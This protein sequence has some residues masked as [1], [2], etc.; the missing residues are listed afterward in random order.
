MEDKTILLNKLKT[1]IALHEKMSKSYFF[2]PPRLAAGRRSY[3]EY[4]SLETV[5]EYKGD[6][7]R[8]SQETKCSC[9]H[10]Y[11]SVKYYINDEQEKKDI[12]FIKK[13]IK[14]VQEVT[15]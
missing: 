1:I 14:E 7:I 2:A 13:I 8:V 9:H 4:N 11:Y 12:R 5:F 6:T 10:V 15:I 3:E